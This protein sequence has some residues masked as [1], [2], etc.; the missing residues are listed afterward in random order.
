ML[1]VQDK[2]KIC[3][4]LIVYTNAYDSLVLNFEHN[5]LFCIN[6]NDSDFYPDNISIQIS[7]SP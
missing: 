6:I 3:L 7:K 1:S 5:H 2:N 4:S